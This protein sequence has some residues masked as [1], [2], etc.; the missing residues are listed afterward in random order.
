MADEEKKDINIDELEELSP[1]ELDAVAGGKTAMPASKLRNF[2]LLKMPDA[3]IQDRLS[4][5]RSKG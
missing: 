3:G 1:E 4:K 5:L 2:R